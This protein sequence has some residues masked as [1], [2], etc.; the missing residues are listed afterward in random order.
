MSNSETVRTLLKMFESFNVEGFLELLTENAEYRFGNYPAA[1][2]QE[3]IAAT[4]KA[5]HLDAISGISFEIKSLY[6]LEDTVVTE[7]VCNYTLKKGGN[8]PL[9]CLDIFKFQGGKV[10]AMLVFMDATPLFTA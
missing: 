6:E 1:V 5:S 7:L 10:T 3:N 4:I 8:L 9:P 2:G